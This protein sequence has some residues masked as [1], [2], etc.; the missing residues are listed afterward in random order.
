MQTGKLETFAGG[1][2]PAKIAHRVGGHAELI[3]LQ[4]GRDVRVAASVDIRID[5]NSDAHAR[6]TFAGQAIDSIQLSFRFGIDRL[7]AQ[8]DR[9]RE[10]RGSLADAGEHNLLGDETSAKRDVD[11][12]ARVRIRAR[13]KRSEQARNS[14][15]RVRLQ[16]IVDRV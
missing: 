9:L 5:P 11:L 8:I 15:R 7:D 1:K 4:S 14:Q 2:A 13:A 3:R 16:R 10:F 6:A 12:A